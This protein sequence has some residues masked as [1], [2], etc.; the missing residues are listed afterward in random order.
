MMLA[1]DGLACD[2]RELTARLGGM[3]PEDAS[4]LIARCDALVREQIACR[5]AYRECAV[6]VRDGIC[7]FGFCTV[8]SRGLAANL[9][10][11]GRAVFY[12][13]TLGAGV[14]RLLARLRAV[15]SLDHYV[16]DA[17]AS[18]YAEAAA[19]SAQAALPYATGTR[20]SPGYGDLDLDFQHTLLPYID[21]A[22]Q[23]GITLDT[24]LLMHPTKSVSAIM[25]VK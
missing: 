18:A 10:G 13:V 20:F 21:A 6:S 2:T 4:T 22:K 12:A 9:S 8:A 17:L 25:R 14:D 24:S 23:A 1:T 11:A 5:Y 3:S 16:C 19:D 15:S 7:D